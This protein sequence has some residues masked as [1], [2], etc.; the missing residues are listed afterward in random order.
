MNGSWKDKGSK[1]ASIVMGITDLMT[2]LAVIFIL[3]LTLFI[4][5]QFAS[6]Q[7]SQ[8]IRQKLIT[9]LT[10][11]LKESDDDQLKEVVVRKDPKDP[12]A[13]T[14][15]INIRLLGFA[16]DE[17]RLPSVGKNFLNRFIPKFAPF[18]CETYAPDIQSIVVEGHTD[19]TAP[20]GKDPDEYN[21]PLSQD[22][23]RAVMQYSLDLLYGDSDDHRSCL[24]DMSS[25]NGRGRREPP[26]DLMGKPLAQHDY[27]SMRR[28]VFKIRIK[29]G[30]QRDVV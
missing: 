24:L 7:K 2:S 29:S 9:A 8:D 12:L 3:L 26:P 22:R 6:K 4:N 18:V 5:A 20:L 1:E 30:E 11:S 19:P 23:A 10:E 13:L 14:V 27:Q 15:E 16:P 28:V 17:A 21:I 25:I